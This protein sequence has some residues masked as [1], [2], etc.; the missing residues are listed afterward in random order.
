[1]K[2]G[3]AAGPVAPVTAIRAIDGR[4]HDEIGAGKGL[5]DHGSGHRDTGHGHPPCH[6]DPAG[7]ADLWRA[8][9]RRKRRIGGHSVGQGLFKDCLKIAFSASYHQEWAGP[10]SEYMSAEVQTI[11]SDT[12]IVE[13]AE[14][15]LKNRY[16]RFPVVTN[17]RLVGMI[18]RYDVLRALE[19]LW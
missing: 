11:E 9:D 18:S 19:E 12:D 16:R 1:M 4:R 3:S 6:Q 13:A 5:H 2:P 15:F 17:G 7:T 8:G 10:V 14:I